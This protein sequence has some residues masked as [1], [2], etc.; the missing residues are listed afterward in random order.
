MADLREMAREFRYENYAKAVKEDVAETG[1]SD[2]MS[3]N[4]RL[5]AAFAEKMLREAVE[6]AR[7]GPNKW[8]GHISEDAGEKIACSIEARF[9]D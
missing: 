6:I 4:S 3:V 7:N 1:G 8:M 5:M 2:G 9:L